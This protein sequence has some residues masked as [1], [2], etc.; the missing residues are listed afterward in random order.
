MLLLA[1]PLDAEGGT[2]PVNPDF[3]P[4][5]HEWAFHLAG[6]SAPRPIRPG[7]PIVFDLDPAPPES[8]TSLPV[9]TP[10]GETARAAVS[11]ALGAAKARFDDTSE[12]GVYRLTKPNP[13]GGFV[14]ATVEGDARG[15]DATPLDPAEAAQLAKGWPLEFATGPDNLSSRM[16]DAGWGGRRELWRGLVLMALAGLCVEVYL[17]RRLVRGLNLGEG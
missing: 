1:G 2:L 10:S 16:F 3:V 17:T 8:V 5:V 7:E 11:R 4:L 15:S 9:S 13:P 6:G 14:Y 12:P